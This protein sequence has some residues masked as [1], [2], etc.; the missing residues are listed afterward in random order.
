VVGA[1][2][3]W[4]LRE[5]PLISQTTEDD[6]QIQR[7]DTAEA[8]Y[9]FALMLN[10]EAAWKSVPEYFPED[11]I[12]ARRAKQH[13]AKIYLLQDYDYQ[14]ALTIF[15]E[16]AQ[17]NDAEVQ[18][19]AFGLAGEAMVLNREHKYGESAKKLAELWPIRGKLDP[20]ARDWV[21]LTWLSNRRQ[22][23][24]PRSQRNWNEWFQSSPAGAPGRESGDGKAAAPS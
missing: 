10:N 19:K 12:Y 7:H 22:L 21:R 9:I 20:E 24:E 4:S 15:S 23:D 6:D 2:L 1:L 11:Q 14:R 5:R 16:F 17:M 18:F 13:L 8:Q 3:A